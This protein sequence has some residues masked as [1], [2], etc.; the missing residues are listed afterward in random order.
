MRAIIAPFW[1]W[2]KLG[3]VMIMIGSNV[4]IYTARH[5]IEPINRN[6]TGCGIPILTGDNVW[7]GGSCVILAGVCIGDNSIVAEGG[8][9]L[10]DVLSN[11][12]VV[13]SPATIIKSV[14]DKTL[15][16]KVLHT[17]RRPFLRTQMRSG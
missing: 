12:I 8:G 10:N 9:V 15:G 14:Q 17:Y 1:I 6:K 7:I 2:L 16:N 3:L 13:S 5:S 11:T 4:G